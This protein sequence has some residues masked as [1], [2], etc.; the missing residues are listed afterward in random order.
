MKEN[1]KKLC[2]HSVYIKYV[3]IIVKI[4]T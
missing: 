3:A 2:R 1:N 4:A